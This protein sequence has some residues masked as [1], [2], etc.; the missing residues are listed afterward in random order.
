MDMW[1]GRAVHC[2]SCGLW[3]TWTMT[4]LTRSGVVL[5]GHTLLQTAKPIP[6]YVNVTTAFWNVEWKIITSLCSCSNQLSVFGEFWSGFV[7]GLLPKPAQCCL[8]AQW[9]LVKGLIWSSAF[10]ILQ[11]GRQEYSSQHVANRWISVLFTMKYARNR[12]GGA[13]SAPVLQSCQAVLALQSAGLV[14]ML[15]HIQ[16]GQ[17]RERTVG[18]YG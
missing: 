6:H 10:S 2:S 4:T 7:C 8:Y 18:L 17:T 5:N 14:T 12:G 11:Q 16:P 9:L 15:H 13:I 3:R 1:M